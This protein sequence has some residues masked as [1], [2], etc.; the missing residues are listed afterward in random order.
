[1]NTSRRFTS[2]TK[3]SEYHRY[4]VQHTQNVSHQN[5]RY[6]VTTEVAGRKD[7]SLQTGVTRTVYKVP[8]PYI[9][10]E[11]CIGWLGAKGET[12]AGFSPFNNNQRAQSSG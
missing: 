2:L 5:K 3:K 12:L 9:N 11:Y 7:D 4:K 1:M 8:S 10:M 6:G